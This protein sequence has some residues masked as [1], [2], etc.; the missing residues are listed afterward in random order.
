MSDI[1]A[2]PPLRTPIYRNLKSRVRGQE[3]DNWVWMMA[4]AIGH[5]PLALLINQFKPIA[6]V[7][8]LVT[9]AIGLWWVWSGSR[10]LPR[11]IYTAAYI[12]GAEVFWRMSGASIFWEFGKYSISILLLLTMFR[13]SRF[14]GAL[15]PGLY[16]LL[17]LPSSLMLIPDLGWERSRET[18][19][20]NLTGPFALMVCAWFF[21]NF[22]LS[23]KQL[24]K[25][26]IFMA[27][28]C[29]GIAAIAQYVIQTNKEI[30][31]TSNAS[32]F[33][34]SGG[35]G[36]NQVS[37][38]LGLGA[39]ACFLF[40]IAGK[41]RWIVK[42]FALGVMLALVAQSALT[43]SRGGMYNVVGAIAVA[44]LFVLRDPRTRGKFLPVVLIS[45]VVIYFVVLPALD[46]FTGG[47]LSARFQNTDSTNRADIAGSQ[48]EVWAE[49][50]VF[51]VGPGQARY[52]AGQVAHTE[53][54]RLLAEHGVFGLLAM[55]AML[56]MAALNIKRANTLT[57]KAIAAA[58][59]SW[60]FLFMVNAGMRLAAPSFAFGL[61]FL[62]LLRDENPRKPGRKPLRAEAEVADGFGRK[63]NPRRD[64]RGRQD[65]L[66]SELPDSDNSGSR[67]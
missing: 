11:V 47:A 37:A 12:V 3:S 52:Y 35:F 31:F 2:S 36:P 64:W 20:F 53:V 24:Q 32:N 58:M 14:Q 25:A 38:I 28:P 41:T 42:L 18:F 13:M 61:S 49:Y 9:F 45:V 5:I 23:T 56:L 15:L 43:F 30:R 10:Y 48:L 33:A 19:S 62:L 51:G 29:L 16:F 4:L 44:S 66:P 67:D 1:I 39:L 26:M 59:I 55:L 65:G 7:H 46:G 50:P 8:A 60:S 54:T 22:K 34:T 57:N 27:S 63:A 40:L 21:C 6:T 17:L